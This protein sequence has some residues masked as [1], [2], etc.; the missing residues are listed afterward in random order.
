MLLGRYHKLQNKLNTGFD[1]AGLRGLRSSNSPLLPSN[2]QIEN[3]SC[4]SWVNIVNDSAFGAVHMRANLLELEKFCKTNVYPQKSASIQ[5][6]T[7]PPIVFFSALIERGGTGG[8]ASALR[9]RLAAAAPG[10]ASPGLLLRVRPWEQGCSNTVWTNVFAIFVLLSRNTQKS[11]VRKS[12]DLKRF[13]L[14]YLMLY[15]F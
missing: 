14:E 15:L 8:R 11:T 1:E 4:V 7:S 5:Q 10:G 2:N 3:R 12:A 6:I 13:G 9:W